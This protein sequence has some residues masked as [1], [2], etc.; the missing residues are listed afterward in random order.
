MSGRAAAEPFQP[1]LQGSGDRLRN[2][3][4]ALGSEFAG[5]LFSFWI[6]YTEGHFP[7][8]LLYIKYRKVYIMHLL[9]VNRKGMEEGYAF[10]LWFSKLEPEPFITFKKSV[11]IG[12]NREYLLLMGTSLLSIPSVP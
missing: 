8:W 10:C 7:S 2:C 9:L 1:F 5:Q 11:E 3:L 6:P 12:R 4:L